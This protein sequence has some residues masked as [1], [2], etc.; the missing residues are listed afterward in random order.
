ME[1]VQLE[2][3]TQFLAETADPLPAWK[4]TQKV[5]CSRCCSGTVAASLEVDTESELH[6]LL[7]PY[8]YVSFVPPCLALSTNGRRLLPFVA[9]SCDGPP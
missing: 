6:A 1:V 5:R 8:C 3:D 7:Q 2:E 4:W 9:S